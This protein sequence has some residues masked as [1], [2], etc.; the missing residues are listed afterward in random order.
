MTAVF[1]V[2]PRAGAG[3]EIN[4][5]AN[6]HADAMVAPRA[7]A[8]IEIA[9]RVSA[10]ALDKSPLAQGR[11]LKCSVWDGQIRPGSRPSRRGGN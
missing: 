2:A 8:G 4:A 6:K 11:E 9:E 5:L 3:I 10:A 7:G 1:N